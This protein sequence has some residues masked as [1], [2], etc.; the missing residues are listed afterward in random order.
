[1]HCYV[2][3]S[4]YKS[5]VVAVYKNCQYLAAEK[6]CGVHLTHCQK[7]LRGT[8]ISDSKQMGSM[9][10]GQNRLRGHIS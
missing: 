6:L 8:E 10:H 3:S 1:M 9:M 5:V 7:N 4:E 2:R